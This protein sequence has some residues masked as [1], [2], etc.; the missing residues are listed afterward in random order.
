MRSYQLWL[1]VLLVCPA[2]GNHPVGL[3]STVLVSSALNLNQHNN[4]LAEII[5]LECKEVDD[6]Q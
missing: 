2:L 1:L 3:Y 4:L 6:D 5:M